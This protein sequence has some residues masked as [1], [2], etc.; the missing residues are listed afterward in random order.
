MRP[1]P[2]GGWESGMCGAQ[3]GWGEIGGGGVGNVVGECPKKNFLSNFRGVWPRDSITTPLVG[4]G[5]GEVGLS[6]DIYQLS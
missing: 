3:N 1:W 4:G 5:F 6:Y 2:M